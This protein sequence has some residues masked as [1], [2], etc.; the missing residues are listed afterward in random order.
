MKKLAIASAIAL[1]GTSTAF[2]ADITV[3]TPQPQVAGVFQA[4][5]VDSGATGPVIDIIEGVT[6]A[7]FNQVDVDTEGGIF[8]TGGL[9]N[10]MLKTD[11]QLDLG[12]SVTGSLST[13]YDIAVIGGAINLA[14]LNGAIDISGTTVTLSSLANNVSATATA[15]ATT[16][17]A[18]AFAIAGVKLET[19]AIGAVNSSTVEVM[20]KVTDQATSFGQATGIG[21]LAAQNQSFDLSAVSF[22]TAKLPLPNAEI[23]ISLT[24]ED[25]LFTATVADEALG[26]LLNSQ[27]DMTGLTSNITASTTN[28]INELQN[29]AVFNSAINAAALDAGIKVVASVDPSAWFLNPQTGMVNL[30][31]VAMATTAIGAV[32]SSVTRLGANLSPTVTVK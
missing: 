9:L 22:D 5:A 1:M 11:I 27:F 20:G 10:T 2:A 7:L 26:G 24:G 15:T 32:N 14:R 4:G 31:N 18:E 12:D 21:S 29:I 19:T 8:S 17:T 3:L 16:S 28:K 13:G 6:T 25:S 30:S 23:G